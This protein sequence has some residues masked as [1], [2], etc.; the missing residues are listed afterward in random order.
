MQYMAGVNPL[1]A[2]ANA[3]AGIQCFQKYTLWQEL[4]AKKLIG[5]SDEEALHLRALEVD[6]DLMLYRSA[7]QKG[8]F[9]K[10]ELNDILKKYI[11]KTDHTPKGVIGAIDKKLETLYGAEDD[12]MRFSMLKGIIEKDGLDIDTAIKTVNNTIPDYTKPMSAWARAGRSSGLTPFISWTYYSTP[13]ILRQLRDNPTRAVG[14]LGAL[15]GINRLMGIDPYDEHDIPQ[16]NFSMHRLPIWK[17]GDEITTLKVDKWLP[18]TAVVTPLDFAKGL[19]SGGVYGTPID[20]IYNR[21]SYFNKQ[22][23]H[24]EGAGKAYDYIKTG[25]QYAT[26]DILDNL[27]NLAESKIVTK[28]ARKSDP[29]VQPRTPTQELLKQLGLNIQDYNKENQKIESENKKLRKEKKDARD[30]KKKLEGDYR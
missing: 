23:T 5:L 12:V 24:K 15:Y 4:N 17:D 2:I 16:G 7:K 22:L 25:V 19:T 30:E 3:K 14:L 21:N 27:Y 26:P 9:G 11:T 18:H 29:V 28:E 10:S 1:K 8:L 6:T 20:M 13:I